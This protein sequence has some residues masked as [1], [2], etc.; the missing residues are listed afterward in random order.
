MV[1]A[2]NSGMSGLG[3]SPG[4]EHCVTVFFS[5]LLYS[6][7]ASLKP[8]MNGYWY[9]SIDGLASYPGGIRNTHSYFMC[10]RNQR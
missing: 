4:Q 6:H 5:K 1:S 2:L 9:G 7:S 8:G 3:S 10:Y